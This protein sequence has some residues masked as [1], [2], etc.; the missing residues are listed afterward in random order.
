ME[1]PKAEELN[2]LAQAREAFTSLLSIHEATVIERAKEA[3]SLEKANQELD[4]MSDDLKAAN[5]M[6]DE[7]NTSIGSLTGQLKQA[8]E[9]ELALA[10]ELKPSE[11]AIGTLEQKVSRLE[12]EAKSAE[13][14]AAEICASVGVEPAMVTPGGEVR[15]QSLI[16]QMREI[17]NPGQQMAFF[18]KHREEIIRER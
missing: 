9:K 11:Q 18:R 13:A 12:S 6:L 2:T 1:F 7:A 5:E 3:E 4:A 10:A 15:Q 14:K 17:K 8:Q 16:E